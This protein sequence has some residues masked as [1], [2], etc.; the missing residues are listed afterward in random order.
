[1]KAIQTNG[2]H[3]SATTASRE[4]QGTLLVAAAGVILGTNGIFV[5]E[6]AQHPITTVAFRCAF[7]ALTLLAWGLFSKRLPELRLTGM[8]LLGA[9]ASG[10]LIAASMALHN[11]AIP[12]TSIG[13]STVI[14]HIQP[15]G[16]MALAAWLLGEK[17]TPRQIGAAVIAFIGL[18]LATGVINSLISGESPSHDYMVGLL[19]SLVGSL[20]MAGFTLLAKAMK[21]VT[22]FALTWWQCFIGALATIWWPM[23]DGWPVTHQSWAWLIGLGAIHSGLA[24]V[25]MYSGFAKLS[26]GRIAVLQFVYPMTAFVIDGLVY[27]HTLTMSQIFGLSMMGAAIWSIKRES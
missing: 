22:S 14:F 10:V 21:S 27:G 26:T 12:R 13:V 1:M 8:P 25:L 23:I 16:T 9:I 18:T 19:L 2:L 5:L 17:I 11:A 20:A 3:P 7:G 4:R 24:Y 15:F 6:A